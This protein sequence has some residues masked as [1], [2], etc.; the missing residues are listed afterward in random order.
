MV[1]STFSVDNWQIHLLG[2]AGGGRLL[3][4]KAC[5]PVYPSLTTLLTMNPGSLPTF[6]FYLH[7]P[8]Q[9]YQLLYT[10]THFYAHTDLLPED[11]EGRENENAFDVV[12]SRDLIEEIF[13]PPDASMNPNDQ[14]EQDKENP[15]II[16][17]FKWKVCYCGWIWTDNLKLLFLPLHCMCLLSS[18]HSSSYPSPF[19]CHL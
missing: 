16:I 5:A 11:G 8:I 10:H 17:A 14:G 12:G 9:P 6:F 4:A 19:P 3:V 15:W 2:A 7:T 13:S 1:K 18:L